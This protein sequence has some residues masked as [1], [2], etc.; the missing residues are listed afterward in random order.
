MIMH[1]TTPVLSAVLVLG[2]AQAEAAP[3]KIQLH[4]KCQ[5][6]PT[7]QLGPFTRLAD[8]SA[9]TM[10]G[11]NALVSKDDGK[12]WASTPAFK[13]TKRFKPWPGGAILRTHDGVVLYAFMNAGERGGKW[14]QKTG[15][16]KPDLRLPVYVVRSLDDGKT[17]EEPKLVQD[18]Y[19][20]CIHQMIQLKNGRVV[21]AS[22]LAVRDPGR[23]VTVTYASDDNGKNW[24]QSNIVDLG[25]YGGYGDHGG[26]IECT[27]VQLKDGRVWMLL[28]TYRGK[29]SEAY[30]HDNGLT[31]KDVRPSKI[32]ASGSPGILHRMASGR[33][34][35]LWNR[36]IDPVKRTGRREQLS[37][38]FSEDEGK[39]WAEPVVIGYDPLQPGNRQSA[40]RL[41]YPNV[42]EH[43]PGELWITTG[44]GP[45]R[46]KL[47]E[48]DFVKSK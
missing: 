15:G 45:L 42:Y 14:D 44:Q 5:K 7:M 39:T 2:F 35:L 24:V 37:M 47:Y 27:I 21:L 6:L 36:F 10:S 48:K 31:W 25:R 34:V 29:F 17:W 30:S 18:G 22:Q 19:C 43:R 12:T 23:H 13:D 32:A 11:T 8:G 16:P 3:K 9:L 41:S 1:V 38:A 46:V 40:H 26:G 28:R 4:P 33:I 20:G